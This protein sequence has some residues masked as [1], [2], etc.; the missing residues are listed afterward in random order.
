MQQA[1]DELTAIV[2]ALQSFV[3]LQGEPPRRLSL[4]QSA[5]AAVELVMLVAPVHNVTLSATG[6]AEVVAGA[7]TVASE[8]VELLLDAL[9][10]AGAGSTIELT[11]SEAGGEAVA[12]V[13]GAGELRLPAA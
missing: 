5:R 6:D 12:A 11:V 10:Q 4:G 8:L 13:T 9:E 7:G 3:R 2:R 1:A